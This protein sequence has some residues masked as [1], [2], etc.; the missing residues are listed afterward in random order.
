[1]VGTWDMPVGSGDR[2]PEDYERGRPGWPAEAV[3]QL[4]LPPSATV[5]EIGA[6]TGKLTRLLAARFAGVVA[7]EPAEA[8]RRVLASRCPGAAILAGE[9]GHLP[10]A[11]RSVDAAFAAESFHW[12]HDEASVEEMAR[13]LRDAAPLVL[14]W[15][16]PAGPWEPSVADAEAVLLDR[17]GDVALWHD[18]LDLGGPRRLP[19]GWADAVAAAGFEPVVEQ[20]LVNPQA[21]DADGLV[22]Y[23]ASMGWIADLDD[24]ERLALLAELRARLTGDGYERTWTTMMCWTRREARATD[25]PAAAQR[26]EPSG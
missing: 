5:L 15:N 23:F 26:R 22:A 21:L 13:V 16:V 14:L 11:D 3:D 19:D 17:L 8:M 7:V 4:R 2:W 25:R 1:V 18:P 10:L 9:G 24:A 6:G 20:S 12:F